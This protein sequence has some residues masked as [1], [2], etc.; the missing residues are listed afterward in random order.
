MIE[1]APKKR[2]LSPEHARL[3]DFPNT[4]TTASLTREL[5]ERAANGADPAEEL[6]HLAKAVRRW[7]RYDRPSVPGGTIVTVRFESGTEYAY[8]TPSHQEVIEG[9][10]LAVP[11]IAGEAL[12]TVVRLSSDY[13]GPVKSAYRIERGLGVYA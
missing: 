2:R 13:S 4:L 7:Q 11:G 10:I 8:R 1:F 9:D 5:E 3:T 6:M 12:G